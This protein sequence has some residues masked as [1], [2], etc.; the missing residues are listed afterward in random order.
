MKKIAVFIAAVVLVLTQIP[1]A[2]ADI[3]DY[4]TIRLTDGSCWNFKPQI[5][6]GMVVWWG[7]DGVYDSE[8]FFWN[9]TQIIKLSD[10][11]YDD[12]GPQI[13]DGKIV[14]NQYDGNDLE[15]ML[16]DGS[17][18]V[19]ITNNDVDDKD[20]QIDDGKIVWWAPGDGWD[21]AGVYHDDEIFLWD[22]TQIIQLTDDVY[23][24]FYPRIDDGM[25]T[26]TGMWS[27]WDETDP[28][29]FLWDGTQ[30]IQLSDN[31]YLDA[32]PQID[33]G[34]VVWACW[35]WSTDTEIFLWDGTQTIQLTDM[36]YCGLEPQID[37]GKVV[38]GASGELF[39]WDGTQTIQITD[40][41][42]N[43]GYIQINDGMVVWVCMIGPWYDP[44]NEIFLWDGTNT[45]QIPQYEDYQIQEYPRM[46]DG[47]IVWEGWNSEGDH[48]IFLS[49]PITIEVS[50]DIKPGN[51]PNPVNL[52]SKG[53]ISVAILTTPSFD[54]S[55][56]NAQMTRFGP[57]GAT[58]VKSN[59]EDVDHD[60]DMDMIL[61]FRT[62]DVGLA[63]G[64]T[65]ATLI[66]LTNYGEFFSG[67]DSIKTI[68]K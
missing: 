35:D 28:E 48:E 43:E 36:D 5:D 62:Q 55:S 60:G 41:D 68:C 46:D 59:F 22:G 31:T 61:H 40:N 56:V 12:S 26:W 45:I 8:I 67:S 20:P 49:G 50:V 42:Y 37:D 7:Y 44:D 63:C 6:D 3:G 21:G 51:Y 16:W 29:I 58:P 18:I 57:A 27:W 52:N 30:I 2:S 10:N 66:G 1:I 39:L 17:Q 53:I 47:M 34:M 64:D 13:D 19:Q 32:S 23:Y 54:A 33:D 9:G 24:D 65:D 38:W 11:E 4:A 25:V 15:I 14:W